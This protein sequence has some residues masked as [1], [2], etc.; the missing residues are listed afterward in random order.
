MHTSEMG[1]QKPSSARSTLPMRI[2]ELSAATHVSRDTLRYY[3]RL[4]LITSPARTSGGFR[5]YG[6]E[7]VTQVQFV[8]QAQALGLELVEIRQ[9]AGVNGARGLAQCRQVQPL[10]RARLV[11][12]DSRLAELRVLRRTLGGALEECERRLV[13]RPDAACPVVAQM[14]QRAVRPEQ[15]KS[16][17]PQRRVRRNRR[18]SGS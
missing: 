4:G 12:L 18:G 15:R 17:A 10:L 8:K 3:E 11:E 7:A 9:L 5:S 2:G 14:E 6:P 1:A 16:G 13:E